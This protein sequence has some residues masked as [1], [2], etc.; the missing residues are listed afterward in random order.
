M[1]LTVRGKILL[2]IVF[3]L[4][5]CL[6]QTRLTEGFEG[7]LSKWELVGGEYAKKIATGD[8]QHGHALLLQP[9]EGVYA[10]V[11]GSDRWGGVR[12]EGEVLFL[13][14]GDGYLGVLYNGSK[15]RSRSDFGCIYIKGDGS[16]IQVNPRRDG[17]ASRLL[18]DE[19]TTGLVGPDTVLLNT[20]H[21]FKAEVIGNV[22]HFY[23]NDMET[24][25]LVFPF[26]ERSSG[27]VGFEPRVVGDPVWIDNI[28]I[29]S[30]REF[31]YKGKPMPAIVY[32][33]DS[34]ITDWSVI[35]PLTSP[36]PEIEGSKTI[37]KHISVGGKQYSWARFETDPRG[38]VITGRITEYSG[39][40]PV[41]YFR[42]ILS[43][44]REKTVRLQFSSVDEIGLFVNGEFNGF[45]YRQGYVSGP[46]RPW[47]A[48]YDFWKNPAH[49]GRT[50]PVKLKAGQNQVVIRV[51]NG[52]FASGGFFMRAS[53]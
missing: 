44:D 40:R 49:A 36:R 47:N 1:K 27:L 20:W 51:R 26:F 5:L 16:Y 30:I 22:C 15:N 2:T 35:G 41:A 43:S 8:S 11:K 12:I 3:N 14:E 46:G 28:A 53:Q 7:D 37:S 42:T 48:W 50:V 39:D 32:Q 52:E 34:L 9:N 6:S 13:G 23:F 31:G 17:N 38:A 18:Y 10:L 29:T 24:P 45:V 4:T 19:F 33:P 25:K 21:R